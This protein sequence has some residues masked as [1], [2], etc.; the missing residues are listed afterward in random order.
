[1]G[2]LNPLS[3]ALTPPAENRYGWWVTLIDVVAHNL[4]AIMT[5]KSL[6]SR[7][8]SALSGVERSVIDRTRKGR[9]ASQLDTLEKLAKGLEIDPLAL[10][11][12]VA[13][14]KRRTERPFERQV[15]AAVSRGDGRVRKT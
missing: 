15:G 10:F 12:P 2:L 14:S 4:D 1:M 13:S 6:S 7:Q 11:M 3:R 8:L 9:K 5:A